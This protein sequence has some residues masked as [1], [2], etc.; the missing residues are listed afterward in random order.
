MI[1]SEAV[2]LKND[3]AE[4]SYKRSW[5]NYITAWLDAYKAA[6]LPMWGLT[7]QKEPEARQHKFESCAYTP[8]LRTQ[9]VVGYPLS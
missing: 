6:R 2:C 7:P 9:G 5:A 4:G 3:T 8:G 1:N